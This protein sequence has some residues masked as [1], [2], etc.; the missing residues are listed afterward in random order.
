[1]DDLHPR[2]R[3]GHNQKDDS[4][5]RGPYR[6]FDKDSAQAQKALIVPTQKKVIAHADA[7]GRSCRHVMSEVP[8][9][10]EVKDDKVPPPTSR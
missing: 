8:S 3:K 10:E 7:N 4:S 6:E 5:K 9:G 1:M 2:K